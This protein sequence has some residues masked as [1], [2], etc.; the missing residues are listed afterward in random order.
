MICGVG[1]ERGR[2]V[3]GWRVLRSQ[4][5]NLVCPLLSSRPVPCYGISWWYREDVGFV[6]LLLCPSTSLLLLDFEFYALCV[7]VGQ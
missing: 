6:G 2:S 3:S 5:W 1:V 4:W 7:S